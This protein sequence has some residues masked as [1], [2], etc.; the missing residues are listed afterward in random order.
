MTLSIT[1]T[2]SIKTIEKNV[3]QA[4]ASYMND[5]LA[6]KQA[7][8]LN[9]VQTLIPIWIHR[10]PEITALLSTDAAYSLKGQFGIAGDT[11]PIVN[12][13]IQSV[14]GATIIKL[15]KFST[16]LKGGLE[17]YFQPNDFRNL[18][19]LPQGHVVYN[20]GDLHWLDWLLKRGD[21]VIV[22]NYQY[23]PNTGFGRSGLGTMVSGGSFRVPPVFSGTDN[24]NF[25]TRA[26]IGPQQEK[27]LTYSFEQ[28]L[29]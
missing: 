21:N 27:D 13:I 17:L 23:N 15:V 6:K 4:I 1:I 26:F 11:M 16:N 29:K 22:A 9:E 8:I 20:G 19:S 24:D 7:Q 2:D 3:N 18:L 28:I 14:V 5:L 12:A 10:Q 25:I